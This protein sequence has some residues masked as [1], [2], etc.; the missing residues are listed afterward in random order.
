MVGNADEG[1]SG[2]FADRMI[3][4][5]DP[6][7]II[8]GMTIA[9]LA[10]GAEQ[11]YLYVRCEY[12]HAIAVLNKAIRIATRYGYL[13]ADILGSKRTFHLEVRTAAG[14]YICG[15]ETALLESIEG[16]RGQ[17]RVKPPLPAV[18]GL[19][20]LPTVI[21]NVLTLAAVP[22]IL[23]RG[24][25]YFRDYGVGRSRGTMP[26]QLAGNLRQTGLVEVAFGLPLRQ[27]L[28]EFGGGSRT[29]RPIRAV[30]VGGPLGAY[31][32]ESQFDTVLDYESFAAIG[33]V[34]GHGGIVAFD[35]T[36]DMARQARYAMEFCV[37]RILRQMHAL[38]HRHGARRRSDRPHPRRRREPDP[39][40][41]RPLQHP[42]I[43]VAVRPRGHD[44]LP[45]AVGP[46]PL[47]RRFPEETMRA[48]DDFDFG[49]PAAAGAP[50]SL[51][52]DDLEVTVPAGTSVM[53]AAI[54]A[55]RMIP[56]LCA[57]DSLKP[58]GS[59]RLCLV[60]IDGR[61]GFPASCTTPVEP[62]MAVRTQSEALTRLRRGVMELYIS[63]HP[64]DCLTCSA[65]GHCELQ[66]MAGAVGLRE[67]RYGL[68]GANHLSETADSSNPYFAYDPAKCIV[69]HRCVRA[70][71]EIQGTFAL[72]VAGR[73]FEA[74]VTPG[75]NE[76]FM[77]SECVSC[78]ACVQACPTATLTE[79]RLT[80]KGKAD[81]SVVTTC[82][83][84]GVG[85]GFKA[86]MKGTEV[87][88]MVPWQDG[89]ANEGHACVKGRFAWGYATHRDRITKPMIRART[90]DPWR[91][92]SW[93][94]ALQ[95]AAKEFRRIQAKHGRDAIG[96]LVSS[97]CTNEEDYLV[98]KLVRAAFGNNN[99]DTCARVCHAPTG[100]GLGVTFG[101]S[102]GTQ[103]FRSVDKADV[104]LVI[105]ANPTEG[106]P[107][108]GSRLLRRV[109]EG[110]KL[111]VIDPADHRSG[112]HAPRRGGPS[113]QAAAG[114]QCG[115][116]LR[117]RPRHRH[118]RAGERGFRRRALR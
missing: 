21:N 12:P 62:G 5:G 108:F 14:A 28:Y 107:V 69:C 54:A 4:E 78:G 7:L 3:L 31:L 76:A 68:A 117:P 30:Q 32:P 16:K 105:G 1:D 56:K 39:A 106:H 33:A 118:R 6:Y 40:A 102:A 71:E 89:R 9:G 55:G 18:S 74:R 10:V 17:V 2:T 61:K 36:V 83:Y 8:E 11:G 47:P 86:E 110:A 95:Y 29:G 111:I 38:P 77:G 104:I 75:Q 37:A 23:A 64:L 109:R 22:L 49:T 57:T 101:T 26:L 116:D 84:C 92:V 94:E 114:D 90:T 96:A 91:E 43:R 19:F 13:G 99:V 25:A 103:T 60:E 97:R 85:C 82:A 93:D 73:G 72:T 48:I 88:R 79:K 45:R 59:C 115:D 34:L 27:V 80:E 15:E 112:G 65:N 20:G 41:G 44:A 66:D 113:S 87:V 42:A 58:F 70:C 51:T 63:D 67:V 100:Y 98:Q 50:V 81:R 46:A 24:A 35:D 52:I 53:R